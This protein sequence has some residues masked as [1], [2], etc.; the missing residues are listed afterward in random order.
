MSTCEPAPGAPWWVNTAVI[1][2]AAGAL[3]FVAAYGRFVPWRST[4]V[5]RHVMTFMAVILTVSSLAVA[6]IIFG[7]DW[8]YRNLIRFLCWASVA[9]VIWSQVV[10]LI[11]SQQ[12]AANLG[13]PGS[14][15]ADDEPVD[16][17]G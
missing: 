13:K 8:P 9:C 15:R 3:V 17:T 2:A 12:L 7:T 10:L 6:S 16:S 14:V 4:I 11:R 1:V 5:G